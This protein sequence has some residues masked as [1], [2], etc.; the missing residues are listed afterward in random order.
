MVKVAVEQAPSKPVDV[1]SILARV[2]MYYSYTLA[3][4]RRLPYKDVKILSKQIDREQARQNYEA[5]Q[6]ATA[7]HTKR[8]SAVKT[9]AKYY[10]KVMGS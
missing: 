5:L 8:G 1:D 2:C 7:P 9:L 4:A 10:K 6:I 3:Q